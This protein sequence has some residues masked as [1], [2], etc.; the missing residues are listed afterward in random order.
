M[1]TKTKRITLSLSEDLYSVLSTRANF[2]VRSINGEVVVLL[3][4]ALSSEIEGN[5]S[6]L[7]MLMKA[8]G[9]LKPE[10]IATA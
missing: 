6:I 2:N 9:G 3:E 1:S 7:R 8:Q 4:A 10:H 5:I